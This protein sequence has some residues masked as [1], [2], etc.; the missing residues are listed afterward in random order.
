MHF[1]NANNGWAVGDNGT[2][3]RATIIHWDGTQWTRVS[4]PVGRLTSV[5]MV[6]ANDGWAVGQVAPGG[7]SLIIHWDGLT[8]DVVG[9][10][11]IPSSMQVTLR[12]V[13]MVASLDGWIAGDRGLILH[14]GPEVV[15]ATTTST[16][17]VVVTSTSTSTTVSTAISTTSTSTSNSTTTTTSIPPSP[18]PGFPIES[19]LAG[20]VGGVAVLA[21]LRRRRN[22]RS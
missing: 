11:P 4:A 8:W 12:S 2:D 17:T 3:T 15:P 18:I 5:Y 21:V 22:G 16:S 9:T 6:S 1:L 14:Y 13:F 20:I 7:L 10:V 19:I